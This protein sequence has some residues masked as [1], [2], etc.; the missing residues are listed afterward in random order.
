M[1]PPL[2]DVAES[3]SSSAVNSLN[4]TVPASTQ[5]GDLI[6]V[7]AGASS[8]TVWA[9]LSG[10]TNVADVRAGGAA[11]RIGVWYKIASSDASA[12]VSPAL[13]SAATGRMIVQ[14]RV[15]HSLDT[16]TPLDATTTTASLD[17]ESVSVV[18]PTITTVTD[19]AW[20]VSIHGQ[21][22]STGTTITS[23]GDPGG[24]NNELI[25]CSTDASGNQ[26]AVVS[27][28][29]DTGTAGSYGTYTATSTQSRR[30]SAV[31][32]ALRPGARVV[33]GTGTAIAGGSVVVSTTRTVAGTGTAIATGSVVVGVAASDLQVTVTA[34]RD[35]GWLPASDETLVAEFETTGDQRSWRLYLDADGGGDPAIAGRPALMWSPDGTSA[36]AITAGATERPPIDPYGKVT[37]R[38]NLDVD[39]GAGGW[40]VTFTYRTDDG[41]WL[42]LGDVVTGTGTTSLFETTAALTV[43]AH[44][45]AGSPVERFVGCIYSVEVR[46]GV[47]GT[48]RAN[49]DF[50]VHAAGTDSFT[51]SSGK[52]WTIHSP[53]ALTSTQVISTIAVVGPLATDECAEWIDYTSPRSGVGGSCEYLPEDCCVTYQVRTVG[54]IDGL[55]LVS[56]WSD[57]SDAYCLEW[58]DDYHLIRTT[59][60]GGP[61]W[62]PVGGMFDWDRDRPFTASTG[63]NGTRF[64]ATAPPGGRNLHMVA[65]VTSEAELAT[66]R[67]VLSRP[68][69]LVSP[70]DATELW[71]APVKES[72]RVI[73]VGR[74]RQLTADFI[75]TGPEPAPQLS[76][77]G[78]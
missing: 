22:T 30:W 68:L 71:A 20:T 70:S 35:D 55:I 54:R 42:Q 39:D 78:D 45:S 72:V 59:G 25:S 33:E 7:V 17:S 16:G 11:F 27:Y 64:V 43:G 31:T 56:N 41:V 5:D 49:P 34:S 66:L 52:V 28:D 44:L 36:S 48:I 8:S 1:A 9:A 4:A 62:A 38:V 14:V 26:A 12:T 46:A 10:Y 37:L 58:S 51:D 13:A 69:V 15:Y 67:A 23:W 74:G 63:V 77:I 65:A 2:R 75:A 47:A 73:K 24:A 18:A 57:P 29:Y 21:P 19:G 60:P 32:L 40:T 76:D 50:T 53:A 6:I 61:L 3:E